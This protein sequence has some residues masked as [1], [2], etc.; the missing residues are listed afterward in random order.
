MS[1]GQGSEFKSRDVQ[2]GDA[3]YV[4]GKFKGFK[5]FRIGRLLTSLGDIGPQVSKK[6][7][8]FT[9]AYQKE[10]VTE[11]ERATLELR[12]PEEAAN[13]SDEAWKE[14]N[15]KVRIANDPSQAEILAVAFPMAFDLAGDKIVDLLAWVIADDAE[16]EKLDNESEEK[17]LD[18]VQ[19]LRKQLMHHADIDELFDIATAAR[20]ALG[21]QMSGKAEG[22]RSI[23]SLVGLGQ[24]EETAS[25]EPTEEGHPTAEVTV[26]EE[27][28]PD[29]TPST[30]PS[31]STSESPASSTGSPLST[32]GIDA[33]SSTAPTGEP[34]LSTSG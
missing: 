25:E 15:G 18:Y 19:R 20:E 3:T 9:A 28:E 10:N 1:E 16:L 11:I 13:V 34:S 31:Q 22:L 26:E 5:A 17:V 12:Y 14:S 27:V 8:E 32:D 2:V 33:Q 24:A 6:I 29:E 30:P 4:I 21:D 23:L 7:N